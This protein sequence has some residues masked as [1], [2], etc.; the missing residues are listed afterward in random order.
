MQTTTLTSQT[1]EPA[2]AEAMTAEQWQRFEED[3]FVVVRNALSHDEIDH[4]TE[5]VDAAYDRDTMAG[6]VAD[7][8]SLQMLGAASN[9]PPLARLVDHPAVLPLVWS[10]LG[11]NVH[12]V[13]SHYDV[14]PR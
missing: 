9:C 6:K 5:A 4:Y 1:P 3:G 11:W 2:P 14:H 10:I 12:V 8:G 7:D 13:H